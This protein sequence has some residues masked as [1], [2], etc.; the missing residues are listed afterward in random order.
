MIG[1]HCWQSSFAVGWSGFI[2]V[3]AIVVVGGHG[4]LLP[5]SSFICCRSSHHHQ[6]CGCW[7]LYEKKNGGRRGVI[8][9]TSTLSDLCLSCVVCPLLSTTLPMATW[10]CFFCEKRKEG[11]RG[12]M[13]LTSML[14]VHC[15]CLPCCQQQHGPYL[16]CEK[17]REGELTCCSPRCCQPF[18]I[19]VHCC[20]SSVVGCHIAVIKLFSLRY[21]QTVR[22]SQTLPPS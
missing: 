16:L 17:R 14:P 18:V 13:L 22:Y 4:L 2:I 9:L 1:W 21:G 12:V 3:L 20:H 6:Q 7:L 8:W 15:C 11:G 5:A 10:P 19:V